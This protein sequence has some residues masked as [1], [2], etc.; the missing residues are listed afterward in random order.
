MGEKK[1]CNGINSC[2]NSYRWKSERIYVETMV[3]F[4]ARLNHSL[5]IVVFFVFFPSP[6]LF[7]ISFL[8]NTFSSEYIPY[9]MS[10]INLFRT[11]TPSTF[12]LCF[13]VFFV[14][15][16]VINSNL[17][18]YTKSQFSRNVSVDLLIETLIIFVINYNKSSALLM[19]CLCII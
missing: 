12:N 16:L 11:Q 8:P 19:E 17:T 15:L 7:V 4:I 3:V 2:I 14:R 9:G 18:A 10:S 1:T 13:D 6:T 5:Y